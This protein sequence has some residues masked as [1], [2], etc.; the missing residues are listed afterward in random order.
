MKSFFGMI[1]LFSFYPFICFSQIYNNGNGDGFVMNCINWQPPEVLPFTLLNADAFCNS[2][3]VIIK[4]SVA[5]ATEGDAFTAE[6]SG[7][8]LGF[9]PA[10]QIKVPESIFTNHSYLFTDYRPISGKSIYRIKYTRHDG[11]VLYSHTFS[12]NCKSSTPVSIHIYPNPLYGSLNISS[13]QTIISFTIKGSSGQ[14]VLYS[15][16]NSQRA[17]F[18]ITHLS[19]GVYFTIT[20]TAIGFV[21]DKIIIAGQ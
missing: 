9:E 21:Y 19:P 17:S 3:T 15:K 2:N 5:S 4:W 16:P 13:S 11:A 12:T 10:G 18:N 1:S 6:R 14:H 20:E 8:G 7:D